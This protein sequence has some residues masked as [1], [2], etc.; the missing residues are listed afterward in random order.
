MVPATTARQV[1][2]FVDLP[3]RL[4]EGDPL[5]IPPLRR[6]ERRRLS[7]KNAFLGHAEIRLWLAD[8]GGRVVGRIA[9]I[10]DRLYEQTHGTRV[11]WFGFFESPDP[12]T[13]AAL[14][15][16]VEAHARARGSA[17]V[18]GPANPS[19]NESAGLLVEGFDTAPYI[20]MPHNPPHY[21]QQIE[22]SGYVKLKDLLAWH[23]DLRAPLP[24]RMTRIAER[25]RRGNGIALRT[26]DL[27]AFERDLAIV[28][29]IY[30]S[31]WRHNWGFVPPTPAEARQLAAELKPIIDPELVVFASIGERTVGCAVA[32]PNANQMLKRMNGR[33]LPFGFVYVLRRRSLINQAR[34]MLLGVEPDL[35]RTG[36]YPLLVAEVHQRARRRGYVAG[37]MSWTL[38]DNHAVN[39]GIEA[40]G[41]RR[42]KTYRLYQKTL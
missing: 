15:A 25:L 11:T 23:M 19:L 16:A 33:L 7:R 41:G 37:E 39:A 38:E 34:M 30:E 42:Y 22:G 4:Y 13:G 9:A 29:R 10:D 2:E 21:Q 36:L 1:S 17:A 20:L 3:Y 28:Q 35:R 26:L 8:A 14:L 24:E 27:S 5:W 40:A 18:C 6:D 31:A 12:A 32:V